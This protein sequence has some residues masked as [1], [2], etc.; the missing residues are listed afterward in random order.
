MSDHG[1]K[2]EK[3]TPKRIEKARREGIFLDPIYS[4]KAFAALIRLAET[5][6]IEGRVLFWHTG[7][8]P[9]LFA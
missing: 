1:Q 8:T 4:G 3:P 6:E 7:G 5:K 9:A 2:T